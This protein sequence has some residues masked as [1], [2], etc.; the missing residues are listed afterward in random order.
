MFIYV[1]HDFA[2]ERG[3]GDNQYG[4]FFI[5]NLFGCGFKVRITDPSMASFD[6]A[7]GRWLD[8]VLGDG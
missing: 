5:V 4:Y 8:V 7:F 6:D 3:A 2:A 1:L